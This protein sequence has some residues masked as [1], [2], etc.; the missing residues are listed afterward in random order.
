[1][2]KIILSILLLYFFLWEKDKEKFVEIFL[3]S[4]GRKEENV[5]NYIDY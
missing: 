3:T 4:E 2:N 1:M 5:E